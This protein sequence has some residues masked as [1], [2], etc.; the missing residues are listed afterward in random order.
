MGWHATQTD[1][2]EAYPTQNQQ[3]APLT[4][5]R[6]HGRSN[7]TARVTRTYTSSDIGCVIVTPHAASASRESPLLSE[8]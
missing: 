5:L 6:K 2:L 7:A 4:G 1:R 8:C 3:R